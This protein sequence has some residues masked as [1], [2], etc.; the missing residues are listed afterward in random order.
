ME[1]FASS[2]TLSSTH[3]LGVESNTQNRE[4]VQRSLLQID[5]DRSSVHHE[6]SNC[7]S[8]G[9]KHFYAPGSFVSTSTV[10]ELLLLFSVAAVICQAG[11]AARP[12]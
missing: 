3:K 2:E 4:T 8:I 12:L 11:M 5:L 9:K 1:T 6:Q 7:E 10:G